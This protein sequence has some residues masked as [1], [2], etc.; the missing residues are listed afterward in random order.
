MGIYNIDTDFVGEQLTPPDLRKTKMLAWLKVLLNPLSNLFNINFLDYKIGNSYT[1]YDNSTTYN[2]GDIVLYT[3]KSTY[4]C[5]VSTSVGVNPLNATNWIKINDIFIGSDE[6]VRY[7]AQTILFNY[8]LNRY[9]QTTGIY[10]ANNLTEDNSFVMGNSGEQ[11]SVM[12]NNSI[13]QENYLG[14]TYTYQPYDFTIF[15]P[16]AFYASLGSEAD[17]L[18]RNI[19]DKYNLAGIVYNID[20]Y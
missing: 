8:L 9:F 1:N 6:R 13:Y 16:S 11:S 3:D 4:Q 20:T 12:T 19:A 2:F 5:I 18:I 10:I 14:N 15:V 17:N 7:N